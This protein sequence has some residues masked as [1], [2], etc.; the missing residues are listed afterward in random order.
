[1]WGWIGALLRRLEGSKTTGLTDGNGKNV[2]VRRSPLS[3]SGRADEVYSS[4]SVCCG[5]GFQLSRDYRHVCFG[6]FEA[7]N[8]KPEGTFDQFD[9][10]SAHVISAHQHAC[11]TFD[12][13]THPIN[14]VFCHFYCATYT[15]AGPHKIHTT[16]QATPENKLNQVES[17]SE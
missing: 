13:E 12:R 2:C 10:L 17:N 16:P 3:E 15:Q 6:T 14:V 9:F 7:F 8:E 4:G 5:T 11:A 1:L